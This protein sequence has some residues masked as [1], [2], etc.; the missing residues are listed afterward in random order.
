[1]GGGAEWAEGTVSELV[2]QIGKWCVCMCVCVCVCVCVCLSTRACK[3]VQ[4]FSVFFSCQ[5]AQVPYA[6]STCLNYQMVAQA[7]FAEQ[8]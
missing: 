2:R 4:R 3:S 8:C 7:G 5:T 1:M 6:K